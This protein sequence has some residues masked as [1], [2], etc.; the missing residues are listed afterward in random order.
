MSQ[1]TISDTVNRVASAYGEIG[2]F[3]DEKLKLYY[4]R[5]PSNQ[6]WRTWRAPGWLPMLTPKMSWPGDFMQWC[7]HEV[8]HVSNQTKWTKSEKLDV[9]EPLRAK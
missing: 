3:W 4:W 1:V 5:L 9:A 2:P 6:A 7:W 8:F